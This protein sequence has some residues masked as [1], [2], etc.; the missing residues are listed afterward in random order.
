[1]Q[2][3]PIVGYGE[4]PRRSLTVARPR[5]V[6]A[7]T[8]ICSFCGLSLLTSYP[9]YSIRSWKNWHFSMLTQ[10]LAA[11][12]H[13]KTAS[14]LRKCSSSFA[15]VTMMSSMMHL[16]FCCSP[17]RTVS[18]ARC[19]TAGAEAISNG[20]RLSRKSPRRVFSVSIGFDLSAISICVYADRRSM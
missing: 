6:F 2:W 3:P 19:Q 12:G 18:I 20:R 9:Q 5:C 7:L 16:V 13:A 15:P 17:P 4:V 1:M 8:F 14:R 11:S 10:R